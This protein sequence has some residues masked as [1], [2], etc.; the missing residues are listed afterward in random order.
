MA[1]ELLKDSWPLIFSSTVLMI[2]A[3]IDQ[4]MLKEMMGNEVVGYYSVAIKLIAFFGFIPMV[5]K[6]SLL[7]AIVNAKE[8]SLKLYDERLLNFY[9][10]NFISFLIVAIPLFIFG[11]QIVVLLFGEEY[12]NAGVLLSL[13]SI[14]LFFTNMGV[15]RGVFL[16]SENLLKFSLITMIVGTIVNII[17]NYLWID[18]YGAQGAVVA[19]IVSFFVTIFLIDFFYIKTRKNI[20]IMLNSIKTVYTIKIKGI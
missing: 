14:R 13:M 10:L 17:L 11:E 6:D 1:I 9:R 20:F 4:I 12:L 16:L 8:T 18:N 3:Y 15:A 5:L 2:Q 7:P 19:T